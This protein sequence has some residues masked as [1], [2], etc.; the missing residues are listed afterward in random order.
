MKLPV[1]YFLLPTLDGSASEKENTIFAF[2]FLPT[3]PS[4]VGS[5]K[6][7]KNGSKGTHPSKDVPEVA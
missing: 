3:L 7:E 6:L 4:T 2:S 1:A 5:R